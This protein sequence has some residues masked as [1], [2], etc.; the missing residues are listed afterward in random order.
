MARMRAGLL[1]GLVFALGGV[2]GCSGDD[3]RVAVSGTVNLKGLPLKAGSIAFEPTE[4]GDS[5]GGTGITD[6]KFD[7]PKSHG[8][9]PGKYLVRVTA[10]DG[11]TPANDEAAGPGGNTNIVSKELV[12][13][14]W[15]TK[16]KQQVTVTKEGPNEFAFDIK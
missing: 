6:G 9:K 7:I 14:D 10:G 3:P 11:R 5:R 13:A 12:P 15:N 4:G 16:S 1:V 8:L 2:A